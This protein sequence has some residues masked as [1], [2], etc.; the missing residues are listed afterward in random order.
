MTIDTVLLLVDELNGKYAG[1][2]EADQQD[3][4][5]AFLD[6]A[7]GLL[8]A[9]LPVTSP[10][11]PLYPLA[12]L[13][14]ASAYEQRW[15][16]GGPPADLD[17][18][19]THAQAGLRSGSGADGDSMDQAELRRLLGYLLGSRFTEAEPDPGD[20]QAVAAARRDR[21]EAIACLA[22]SRQR[23][24]AD[25]GD[26]DELDVCRALGELY[27]GR[28]RDP[29]PDPADSGDDVTAAIGVLTV[30]ASQQEP[31]QA[32]V[33]AL[34]LALFTCWDQSKNA[35]DRD[36]FIRWGQLLMRMPGAQGQQGQKGL[37]SLLAIALFERAEN[38]D[39]ALAQTDTDAAI[40]YLEAELAVTPA[41]DPGR[42]ELIEWLVEECWNR[43]E[44][45][46]FDRADVDRMTEYA[47]KAWTLLPAGSEV[48]PDRAMTGLQFA[49]GLLDRLAR[50]GQAYDPDAVELAIRIL[51]ELEQSESAREPEFHRMVVTM[52]ANFQAGRAQG[53]GSGAA[54]EESRQ[55]IRQAA[56]ELPLDDPETAF[57]VDILAG[58][59][60]A[61]AMMGTSMGDLDQAIGVFSAS[62]SCPSG[63][64]QAGALT[65]AALG[66]AL[67]Q[68]AQL[69]GKPADLDHGI[70]H[71]MAS[72]ELMPEN[73]S[74]RTMV[75]SSLSSAL[76]IR[77]QQRGDAQDMDAAEYYLTVAH[78]WA[79]AGTVD[80]ADIPDANLVLAA[81]QGI[82]RINRGAGRG[83]L[84]AIDKGVSEIRTV[85]A[86]LTADHP[87]Y[88]RLQS[89][90]GLGLIIRAAYGPDPSG[91]AL[92]AIE[93]L[94]AV[95]AA[96]APG[97]TTLPLVRMRLCGALSIVGFRLRDPGYLR[98]AVARV[99]AAR[100]E[101]PSWFG[102]SVRFT[103]LLGSLHWLLFQ[104]TRSRLALIEA[105]RWLEEGSSPNGRASDPLLGNCLIDLAR[106]YKSLPDPRLALE[107]AQAALRER[108]RDVLLQTGTARSLSLAQTAA[109]EAVEIADW[110]LAE[111]NAEDAAGVLEL[112]RGLILHSA[113]AV[114][115]VADM[116]TQHGQH[117]LAAEWQATPTVRQPAPWD[118]PGLP[119]D[120]LD[121]LGGG[122]PP[123]IP[124]DLRGRVLN[125]LT[126][127]GA[128]PLL[129]P[130][131]REDIANAL[132]STGADA[133]VYLLEATNPGPGH[134][135][136]VPASVPGGRHAAA[137][138]LPLPLLHPGRS[139]PLTRYVK[140]DQ[141]LGPA[142]DADA[143]R[144]SQPS[145]GRPA[146]RERW[147]Q[148][149][150]QLCDWAGPAA[151]APLLEHVGRWAL[152]RPARLVLV[153]VGRL[154]LVPWHAVRLEP[155]SAAGGSTGS[156]R[157]V[158]SEAVISYAA[159][160]R[161]LVEVSKRPA[162]ALQ[163]DPVLVGNPGQAI[164]MVFGA[165]EAHSIRVCCYPDGRYLGQVLP[166]SGSRSDGT[167]QPAEILRE[168]PSATQ[169]GASVLHLGCHACLVATAAGESYLELADGQRLAIE[170]ILRQAGNR[171]AAAPGGLVCLAACSSAHGGAA[172]DE[173]L[174]LSTAFLAAGATTV[175]GARWNVASGTTSVLMFMFHYFLAVG[176]QP[177]RDALRSAQL[178]MLDPDRAVP[179]QLPRELA[180]FLPGPAGLAVADWAA[181]THQGR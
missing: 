57:L 176:G 124:A 72:W 149:L 44:G 140:A 91:D 73:S 145:P 130:L 107:T 51:L 75:V 16:A 118:S 143:D 126:Q 179:A 68:R 147:S 148:A 56:Q 138:I 80:L 31:E 150:D 152:G 161:Q 90:L 151:M 41:D 85:L 84:A 32:D 61:L 76:L 131:A 92:Q 132:A 86:G 160:G 20:Q 144:D 134:A 82:V 122:G 13:V 165:L 181:F 142:P 83:D 100:E 97:D 153:P 158:C 180:R 106:C 42:P 173:A 3:L 101:L 2:L 175:I 34:A 172:Y 95:V 168:L 8:A 59:L 121:L 50:P 48:S 54:L 49:V 21:D 22:D 37:P 19:I 4:A 39:K 63:D 146:A 65:R 170:T 9:A 96:A 159:S 178:W 135:I 69:A 127:E 35:D 116:L 43:L 10:G 120:P 113:T 55:W 157:Y 28:H 24:A 46:S 133:L 169:P 89:D 163:S 12:S 128:N 52:L 102:E 23:A 1:A 5:S 139:G 36:N 115:S 98:Q 78:D 60:A 87:Y 155:A 125:A 74:D 141:D 58:A 79:D 103:R 123:E 45:S 17:A 14:A 154:S 70:G 166:L 171:P 88:Q 67:I 71:L 105:I 6:E 27:V 156:G 162:L 94:E 93:L 62:L 30:L 112:G 136:I 29:W 129:A 119:V 174:S 53:I 11:H 47:G 117:D 99:S 7:I 137:M 33:A 164:D 109:K 114:T 15:L 66:M 177:P 167:G 64:P 38:A 40:G 81:T 25:P 18:A 26:P 111:G 104:L 77:Y 110:C 108:S